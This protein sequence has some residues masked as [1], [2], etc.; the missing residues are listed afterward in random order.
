MRTRL[1]MC[2]LCAALA[3]AP[4][5]A[6]A[7]SMIPLAVEQLAERSQAVVRA[8]TLSTTSA[9]DGHGRIVTHAHVRVLESLA[10]PHAPGEELDVAT[11]G[12]TV[13][14]TSMIVIGAPVFAAG[15]EVVLFLAP[16]DGLGMG[17]AE[18]G[19][20]KFEVTRDA[21]GAVRLTRRSLEG[22]DFVH[23]ATPEPVLD[24]TLLRLHVARAARLAR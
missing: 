9:W 13:G 17:I 1:W 6:R 5:V 24:L 21:R 15:E 2:V 3:A 12:G 18:L 14:G 20:G 22:V 7:T 8:Q 19:Q 23:G 11:Y 4:A 16:Q 10:G